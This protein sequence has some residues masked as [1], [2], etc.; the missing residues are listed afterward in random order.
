MT[1]ITLD[2]WTKR[3]AVFKIG[4][5]TAAITLS[6]LITTGYFKLQI[7]PRLAS[8]YFTTL[9]IYGVYYGPVLGG[10][11]GT[12]RKDGELLFSDNFLIHR[13]LPYLGKKAG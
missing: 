9:L 2:L 5:C 3:G 8:F 10:L 7:P 4:L 6:V 1:T 11:I 13:N 12:Y